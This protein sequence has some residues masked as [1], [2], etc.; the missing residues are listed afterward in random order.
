MVFADCVRYSVY[1]LIMGMETQ[2]PR[3]SRGNLP[4]VVIFRSWWWVHPN[5]NW[6]K[7]LISLFNAGCNFI[8]VMLYNL[9]N[10]LICLYRKCKPS[11]VCCADD[12]WRLI[13]LMYK[14]QWRKRWYNNRFSLL[15]LSLGWG[16]TGLE[17]KARFG[18]WLAF[19]NCLLFLCC[20]VLPPRF[21]YMVIKK[22]TRL[23]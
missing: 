19:F 22:E 18:L 3:C 14:V 9:W 17:G 23:P 4:V 10:Q 20:G 21:I 1:L 8:T 16:Q 13:L 12:Y 6:P 2:W 5:R 7:P 15:T 11:L